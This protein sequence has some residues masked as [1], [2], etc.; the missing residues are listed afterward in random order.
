MGLKIAVLGTR[1][2]PDV[3][4]GIETH[5]QELYPR[6]VQRGADV[7]IFGRKGYTPKEEPYEYKGVKVIPVESPHTAGL[8]AFVHTFRCIV[9]IWRMHPDV[10]HLHAIGPAFVAPLFRMLGLKVVYTHHGQDYNRAKWGAFAKFVLR[11]SER[12]GTLFS[13]RVIVIS[14]YLDSWLQEKYG[15]RKTVFIRNGVNIPQRLDDGTAKKWLERH[16]L[17]GKRYIFA[18]GRFVEEKG[19]HDLINAYKAANIPDVSLVIAGTADQ[20]S[21]YSKKLRQMACE[22]GVVLPGFIYGE[23]LQAVF[24]NAALFVIPSYHEGLPIALLEAL[25]YNLDVIASDISANTEVPLPEE[26]FFR[27]GDVQ[28]LA[29]KLKQFVQL[30]SMRDYRKI[31]EEFYNWER[32]AD[33]TFEVYKSI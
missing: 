16:G 7:T 23:E 1:G 19:F 6:L 31:V 12:M 28:A 3:M 4:G 32:I 30:T 22:A 15:C 10:V 13:N 8:E 25:S 11:L 20:E 5:C 27:V 17:Y 26:S 14:K 18:L 29:A 9:K 24:E 2:I 33:Q 21:P